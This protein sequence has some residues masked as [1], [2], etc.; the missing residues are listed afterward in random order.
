MLTHIQST[1]ATAAALGAEEIGVLLFK[2]IFAIAPEAVSLF[3]FKV[4]VRGW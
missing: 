1:W 3:S 4:E 2:N